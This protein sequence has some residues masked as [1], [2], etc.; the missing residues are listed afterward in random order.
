MQGLDT[1]VTPENLRRVQIK[2]KNGSF[3]DAQFG[4][5]EAGD[6]FRMYEPDG[7]IVLNEIGGEERIADSNARVNTDHRTVLQRAN[8]QA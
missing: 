4:Q 2:D 3:V 6:V 1:M 5:I 7:T 8:H